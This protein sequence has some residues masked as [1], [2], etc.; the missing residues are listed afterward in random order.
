MM[1]ATNRDKTFALFLRGYSIREIA[2]KTG[3]SRSTIERYSV[4]QEWVKN[5]ELF[6]YESKRKAAQLML[7]EDP[8][9]LSKVSIQMADELILSMRAIGVARNRRYSQKTV[10]RL[11]IDALKNVRLYLRLTDV[12]GRYLEQRKAAEEVEKMYRDRIIQNENY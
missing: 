11:F 7:A 9:K 12:E 1:N 3:Y 4:K 10:S 6:Q 5:R 2:K 8:S